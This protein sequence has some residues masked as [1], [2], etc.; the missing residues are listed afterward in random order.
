MIDEVTPVESWEALQ[1]DPNAV[2]ID[3]RTAI[4][5]NLIG[6]P[7]LSGIGKRLITLEWQSL[8]GQPNPNFVNQVS[9]ILP[10]DTPIHIMCRV[11]GRSA[12]ACQALSA[13]GYTNLANVTEGFEGQPDA[14]G[15]RS[16]REGWKFHNLPWIQS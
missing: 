13:A 5:W 6:V 4:E 16:A 12:A 11:G 1:N 14:N 7:D 15:H 9:E 3:C 2:L 8:D 10:K